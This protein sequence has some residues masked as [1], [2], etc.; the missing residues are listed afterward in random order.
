MG[1][2]SGMKFIKRH[3]LIKQLLLPRMPLSEP[4]KQWLV[5]PRS[6]SKQLSG[7]CGG[8]FNVQLLSQQT[9]RPT[10]YERQW[11][12]LKDRQSVMVRE[13][14]LRCGNNPIVFARTVVGYSQLQGR[15]RRLAFLRRQPLG[16]SCLAR[17]LRRDQLELFRL[18]STQVLF[19]QAMQVLPQSSSKMLWGRH[20]LFSLG[21]KS[22]L[23]TEVF[24]PTLLDEIGR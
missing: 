9:I 5:D 7:Y 19:Q 24:S 12:R 4:W 22:L 3:F 23:V 17:G 13:V 20:S 10:D 8:S 11:L 21:H 2:G 6:L 15:L 16:T 18:Q 14:C 1:S